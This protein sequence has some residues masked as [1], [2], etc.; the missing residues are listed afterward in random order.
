[1]QGIDW[2]LYQDDSFYHELVDHM[3]ESKQETARLR[4]QL[5]AERAQLDAEAAYR[6]QRMLGYA[7]QLPYQQM[8]PVRPMQW[9][10]SYPAYQDNFVNYWSDPAQ[11]AVQ[12]G[13]SMPT[14][15]ELRRVFHSAVDC[16]AQL[17]K[18]KAPVPSIIFDGLGLL[19]AGNL[20]EVAKS[21]LSIIDT[22][23][24]L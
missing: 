20:F 9:S 23:E 19:T 6:R 22:A 16:T 12:S 5:R 4:Q 2:K 3:I 1:M 10:A 18:E 24:R 7:N 13:T 11:S 8:T 15:E 21:A 17:T 14:Q